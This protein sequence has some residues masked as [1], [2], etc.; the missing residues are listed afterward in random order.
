MTS[1]VRGAVRG[2]KG[3]RGSVLRTGGAGSRYGLLLVK[4]ARRRLEAGMSWDT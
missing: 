4:S 3:E 1:L 2:G